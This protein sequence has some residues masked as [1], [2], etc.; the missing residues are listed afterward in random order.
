MKERAEEVARK[1]DE[2]RR[3]GRPPVIRRVRRNFDASILTAHPDA[4]LEFVQNSSFWL[5]Q[6][7]RQC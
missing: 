7:A 4:V 1:I 2:D 5:D 6:F 3:N